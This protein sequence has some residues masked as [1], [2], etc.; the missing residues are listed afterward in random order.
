MFCD[1][2]GTKLKEGIAFCPNC[3]KKI[4]DEALQVVEGARKKTDIQDN[5][6]AAVYDGQQTQEN[7]MVEIQNGQDEPENVEAAV[8]NVSKRF[9]PNCGTEN[10][11]EDAF[12]KECGMPLGSM[13]GGMVS[14][15]LTVQV[16]PVDVPKSKKKRKTVFVISAVVAVLLVVVVLATTIGSLLQGTR[17]KVLRATAATMKDA[18]KLV[19]DLAAISPMLSGEHYTV[20]FEL[21]SEDGA[22]T[23]E[24]R[25]AKNEKQLYFNADVDDY[26]AFDVLCGIHSGKV[27]LALSE[28]D[29]VFF[30]DPKGDNDGF[31]C[32]QV[33]KKTLEEF[34]QVLEGIASGKV[35]TKTLKKDLSAAWMKELKE[36]EFKEVKAREFEV[37]NKDRECKG[38]RIRITENNIANILK[39]VGEK[40][41]EYEDVLDDLYDEIKHNDFDLD[42]TFYIYKKKLAAVVLDMDNDKIFI[43]FQGGDYRMQNILLRSEYNGR[44]LG[45]ITVSTTVKG[46]KETIEIEG[47]GR[48]EMTVV[49][50]TKSGNLSLEYDDGREDFLLSGIYKHSNS[51][52][53]FVL[54]ELEVDGDSL[55]DDIGLTMYI[56]KKAD[57]EQYKGKEFDLG[58]AEEEDFEDLIDDLEDYIDLLDEYYRIGRRIVF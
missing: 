4:S 2:C 16:P 42:V 27:K 25:N 58:S 19:T 32:E 43:E 8:Q 50:D 56:R 31:L 57:I 1:Q 14:G 44:E 23:T 53:S 6:E 52:V 54:D 7:T 12:C 10:Q 47:D 39:S 30:Y 9:C 34:N 36:L 26:G 46:G 51:E 29:Y 33:R 24:F 13:N 18:P 3:G 41:E 15:G 35:S 38:Y 20:G 21:E 5:V 40:T 11:M 28:L 22:V 37:D 55:M 48:E 49:Y 45:E 17:G